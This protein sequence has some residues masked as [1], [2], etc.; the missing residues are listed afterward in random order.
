MR[1]LAGGV[2]KPARGG[3]EVTTIPPDPALEERR[4]FF[5]HGRARY[6]HPR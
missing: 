1:R 3:L 6:R 5:K 4:A 2:D